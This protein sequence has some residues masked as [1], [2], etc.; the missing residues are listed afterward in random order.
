[1]KI[2]DQE[3]MS[4]DKI[5]MLK[6]KI[7]LPD[8]K[9]KG[10][11]HV[12]HGMDE[13][14]GRYDGFMRAMAEAGY[15]TFG[16]DHLGHGRTA[17]DDSEL[18]YFAAKNGWVKLVDD[19]FVYGNTV[20]RMYEPGLPFILMGHSMGSFVVRLTAAK[21]H[22]HDK[23]IAMGTGGPNP[24]AGAG[25]LVARDIKRVKGDRYVSRVIYKLAFG[26][27][28]QRFKSEDDIYAWLSVDKAN[29][30]RYRKDKYCTFPFTVSAM[31]DLIRM[32]RRCNTKAW[33]SAIDKAKPILLVS[34]SEDPVGDYGE[35]VKKV[36]H[37]LKNS[38]ANVKMKLYEGYRHEIL[39]DYCKE[40]VT[41]DV[42]RFV[43]E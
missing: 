14:I 15:I 26:T 18:G 24:A 3:V 25:I 36:Y 27:Y 43:Q 40:E 31:Q 28:N 17:L 32:N 1:M 9:P 11:F 4:S 6:G 5:H 33:F 23:L 22:H 8:G 30:D 38:G 42:L 21:Y 12:V 41:E 29:R 16:Y 34:G 13:Y 39:Q 37:L 19:V 20:R 35:G 2:I 10:L 7:Y